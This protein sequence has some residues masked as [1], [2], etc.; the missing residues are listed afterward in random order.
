MHVAEIWRYPVK[1]LRGER[2]DSAE[3]TPDG[4]PGDRGL[5]VVDADGELVTA[6]VR[7]ELLLV[8]ATLSGAGEPLVAG[9]RWES[10][11]A[12]AAIERAAGTGTEL[13]RSDGGHRYDDTPL[14]VATDGAVAWMGVDGRRFR[15]NIVIAGVEGLGERGWPGDTL[16]A[17]NATIAIEKLCRRCVIPTVD[18]D[19]A[20]VD[21]AVLR[22][23]NDALDQRFALNCRVSEPG[24][25]AVGDAVV[26]EA[27]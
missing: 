12:A 4:I 7:H 11:E 19:T 8:D 1:S 14:L 6:R 2:L 17:G 26:L 3:L 25:V 20:A 21:P 9:A 23:I 24:R 27:A 5:H 15:P 22:R 16:R 18:P 10:S 13:R